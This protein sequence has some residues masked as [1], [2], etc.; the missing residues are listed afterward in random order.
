M[1]IIP[2][3]NRAKELSRI[4]RLYSESDFSVYDFCIL[5]GS[6]IEQCKLNEKTISK[7]SKRLRI[8]HIID[9]SDFHIRILNYIENLSLNDVVILA[10]DEDFFQKDYVEDAI[11]FLKNNKDYCAIIGKYVTWQKPILGLNRVSS[12]REVITDGD[13][14][15]EDGGARLSLLSKFL[16]A[17]CSPI[18]WGARRVGQLKESLMLQQKTYMHTTR[19]M[20][21]QIHLALSG[22]IKFVDINMLWRDERRQD[23][24][25][26]P[27]RADLLNNVPLSSIPEV[28]KIFHQKFKGCF[29]QEISHW[30][31]WHFSNNL[32]GLTYNTIYY[33]KRYSKKSYFHPESKTAKFFKIFDKVQVIL[34]E[35][36]Y[37]IAI[38]KSEKKFG[39]SK[40][41]KLFLKKL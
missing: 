3:Y 2:T 24:K 36:M 31:D 40:L 27:Q 39:K 19:E 37:S 9:G 11:N 5:D 17:G 29:K 32:N 4:L 8:N 35:I 22:K 30:L 33:S 34:S 20:V 26:Y 21:D 7:Y 12:W 41:I 18:F 13:I 15:F 10:N 25:A 1:I 16:L 28:E 23:F 6:D 38:V 14:K